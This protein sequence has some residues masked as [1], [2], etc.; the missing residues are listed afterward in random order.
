LAM[1]VAIR[2]VS[3]PVSRFVSTP[4]AATASATK[5]RCQPALVSEPN[6]SQPPKR[7]GPC[8]NIRLASPVVIKHCW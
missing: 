6:N 8:R 2:R 7:R 4:P 3:S 5:S 1:L